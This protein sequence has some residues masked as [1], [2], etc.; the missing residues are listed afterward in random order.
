MRCFWCGIR[1]YDRVEIPIFQSMN[2][3]DYTPDYNQVP[4]HSTVFLCKRCHVD[5]IV[6]QRQYSE[7]V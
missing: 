6:L 1:L 4:S 7:I 3:A 2:L 5:R